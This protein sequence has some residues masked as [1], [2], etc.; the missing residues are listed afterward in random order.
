[1]ILS[2][3]TTGLVSGTDTAACPGTVLGAVNISADGTNACS[4]TL[5]KNSA[6]GDIIFQQST[7]T[8][9]FIIAPLRGAA[10]IHYVISGTG[11]SAQLYEWLT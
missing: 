9:M 1:M 10:V 2:S 8:P 3:I 11:G 7:K 6:S 4:V 5:R